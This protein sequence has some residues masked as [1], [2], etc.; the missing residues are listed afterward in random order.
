VFLRS[1]DL[2]Q[3]RG[4]VTP[5]LPSGSLFGHIDRGQGICGVVGS[6]HQRHDD[7]RAGLF[8]LRDLLA[9]DLKQ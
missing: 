7:L 4:G 6:F 2:R 9:F 5:L 3:D 1:D 8:L